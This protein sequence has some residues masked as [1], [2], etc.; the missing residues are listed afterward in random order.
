MLI[1]KNFPTWI[2]I[3]WHHSCQAIRGHKTKIQFGFDRYIIGEVYPGYDLQMFTFCKNSTIFSIQAFWKIC[4]QVIYRRHHWPCVKR[5]PLVIGGIQSR[6]TS[7]AV[8][9]IKSVSHLTFWNFRD[10]SNYVICNVSLHVNR[11]IKHCLMS[12]Y[13]GSLLFMNIEW[14]TKGPCS[15][16]G[17]TLPQYLTKLRSRELGCLK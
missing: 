14:N 11:L 5:N 13:I 17:R 1:N 7:K 15:L 6:R 8:S 3:G 4:P 10:V 9:I 12:R 2:L 16:C